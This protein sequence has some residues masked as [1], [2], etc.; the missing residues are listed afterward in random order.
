MPKLNE[1][2]PWALGLGFLTYLML[3]AFAGFVAR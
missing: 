3:S 2:V 1:F